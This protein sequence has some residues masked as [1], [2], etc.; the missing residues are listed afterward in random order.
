MHFCGFGTFRTPDHGAR[1]FIGVHSS[2]ATPTHKQARVV[3]E[4]LGPGNGDSPSCGGPAQ[5]SGY[6]PV[7]DDRQ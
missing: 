3:I 5:P 7:P 4:A 1:E 6:E 2:A